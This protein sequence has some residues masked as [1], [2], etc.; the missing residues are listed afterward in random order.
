M[1]SQRID[2]LRFLGNPQQ[3][4]LPIYQRPYSWDKKVECKTLF[5]DLYFIGNAENRNNWY[6]G[7][8]VCQN[9]GGNLATP[10]FVLI[11]GQ[12][13]IT[14]VTIL[15]CAIT[16]YLRKH[17]QTK[18]DEVKNWDSLLKTYVVNPEAEGDKWY[19][20]LLNNE[21][22][23]DLQDLIYKVS[24]G[25]DVPKY[26]GKSNV[27]NNYHFFKRNINKNNIHSIY[28][29]LKKLEMILISLDEND[30]A[31]NIFETLNSTGRSLRH[32]DQIRNYLLMGLDNQEAEELY[33][34]YWRPMET[35][36]EQNKTKNGVKDHFDYFTRYYLM[37]KLDMKVR[38]DAVYDKFRVVSDNFENAKQCIKELHEF[39]QY[40]L[41]IFADCETDSVL[42]REFSELHTIKMRVMSPFL[43]KLYKFYVEGNLSKTEFIQIFNVLKSHYLR[44]SLC[45]WIGNNG[46]D[47]VALKLCKIIDNGGGYNE[48]VECLFTFK[49]NDRFLSNAQVKE[50]IPQNFKRYPKNHFVLSKLI[51][52]GQPAPIDTSELDVVYLCEKVSDEYLDKLGN[53]TLEGIDLCMDIEADS[54][55]EFI[56]KRTEALTDLI[57]KVW[58]YPS[59]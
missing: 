31:Q 52:F 19:R 34:H 23:E 6:L 22:K 53:L 9:V 55:E 1:E 29:G 51:N 2:T 13:R 57:L 27:F 16:E 17:P 42:K 45:G 54:N 59:L 46:L 33:Y 14:T 38:T 4:V 7:A 8:V 11:D 43:M 28:N 20:L 36:F 48:V 5:D 18:L 26:K 25:E 40:Y 37:M 44:R 32:V 21:D 56:D 58:E 10:V 3:C 50:N 47:N 39:S 35:A 49:G 12:Q 41:N 15:I 24:V 30:V